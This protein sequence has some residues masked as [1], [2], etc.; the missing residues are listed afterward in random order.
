MRSHLKRLALFAAALL[1]GFVPVTS[2]VASSPAPFAARTAPMSPV[3]PEWRGGPFVFQS[4]GTPLAELLRDFGAHHGIPTTV[5]AQVDD[6][7]IGTLPAGAAQATLDALSERYR[8]SWYFNGQTLNIYKS[9]EATRRVMSLRHASPG[10]LLEHLRDAGVLHPRHC[11][12]RAIPA[13]H[14]L[15]IA[16]VPACIETVSMLAEYVER[17]ARDQQESE[18]TIKIFPLKFATADDTRYFYR[19]QE[20]VVPGVVSVLK[21]LILGA[22]P[23]VVTA[24]TPATPGA[25]VAAAPAARPGTPRFS[26]DP[27]RNAVIVRERRQNLPIYGDLIA[28]LDIRPRLVDIS[29]AIIDVNASDI[30]ELGVDF[31]G[32]AR[33]GGFGAVSLN[34]QLQDGDSGT[35]TTVVGDTN[36]FMVN[37]S[38][39][40]RNSKARVLSRPSIVTL[41][42]MQAVLDRSVTFYT[43]VSGEKV[44]KLES[45][46]SGSLLRVTPRLVPND[47]DDA[48]REQVMLTLNIEDGGEVRSERNSRNEVPTIRNSSISTHA[49]LQAGQSLLLGGFVQDTQ[50]EHERKIPLL[51][52]LPLIGRLF[53]STSNRNDSVMRLFLIKAEPAADVPSA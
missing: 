24:A 53:S 51:G 7:F 36:K 31:S 13:T 1:A 9:S 5:S 41:D 47:G 4:A 40:E 17:D 45:V 14:A 46:T 10:D 18:E 50:Q 19:G 12:A 23:L 3:T 30:A 32:N 21:D 44:A 27:R 38:A 34:G 2:A 33:I 28:Q 43:K 25:P 11:V 29:V 20:V 39:L 49:T 15:E 22:G 37:L 42:N 48:G 35:F 52:D 26:A 6:R 8:L 16:G